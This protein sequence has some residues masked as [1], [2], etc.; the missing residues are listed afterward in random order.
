MAREYE[1]EGKLEAAFGEYEAILRTNPYL[2]VNYRDAAT[3][4]IKLGD[5]PRALDY[6]KKSLVYGDS[7]YASYRMGEIYLIKGDYASSRK[8]FEEA[9]SLTD[10][11]SE[12]ILSNICFPT[13]FFNFSSTLCLAQLI[14]PSMKL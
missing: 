14:I 4:L 2:A 1:E 12:K 8:S 9:F 6:F 13:I 7:F 11:G 10:D 5:L 3:R